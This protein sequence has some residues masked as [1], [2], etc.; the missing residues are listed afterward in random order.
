MRGYCI[1][2]ADL[3]IFGLLLNNHLIKIYFFN[4]FRSEE[5]EFDIQ[6]MP[7]ILI[8]FAHP[9]DYPSKTCPE[10]R[11]CC[12]WLTGSQIDSLRRKF[13]DIWTENYSCVILFI[14]ISVIKDELLEVLDINHNAFNIDELVKFDTASGVCCS[15]SIVLNVQL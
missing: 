7:P 15:L 14:W 13:Q 6:Y 5:H 4:N 3:F 9:K 2:R 11:I 12:D 10:F 8:E 1:L